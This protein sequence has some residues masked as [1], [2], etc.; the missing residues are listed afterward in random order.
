MAAHNGQLDNRID[1]VTPENIAFHYQVAG[2][3]RRLPAYL[4]DLMIR[5]GL[6]VVT[7]LVLWFCFSMVGLPDIGVGA[8]LICWFVLSWFY[9]G[10]FETF[11]NGQTPGKRLM[12]IRVLS[13]D[14]Q[15]IN[16]MQAVMRN[17]LRAVDGWPFCLYVVGLI[18]AGMN[19]RF[20][21]LGDLACG[22]MVVIEE[23]KWF[24]GVVRITEPAAIQLAA[25]IP[26]GFPVDRGLAR[27]LASYVQRRGNFAWPR[28]LEI[29]RHL[30][31][32]LL[33]RLALPP[34]T[35]PD[36]LLAALYHR[37][38]IGDPDDGQSPWGD[39]AVQSPFLAGQQR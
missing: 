6:A 14:G 1:I 21:R 17:V 25:Q 28:R 35:D 33:A 9:G 31:E 5:I 36:L 34:A 13:I 8:G 23:P 16:G 2:P 3:F 7:M 39:A 15:P 27:G 10:L 37:T 4:I 26:A 29:A 20:Q 32:P 30:G 12:E 38:F 19:N 22:T 18:A 11:W 24:H